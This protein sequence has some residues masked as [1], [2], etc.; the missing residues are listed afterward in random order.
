MKKNQ[1]EALV[2][3]LGSIGL[4][5]LLGGIFTHLYEF[6]YGLIAAIAIWILAGFIR[7]FYDI[8]KIK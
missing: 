3:L 4:L 8:K 5:I 6:T 2:W 1:K 7:R